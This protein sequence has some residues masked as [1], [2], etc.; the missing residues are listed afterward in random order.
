MPEFLTG[1]K[2]SPHTNCV[3]TKVALQLVWGL[4]ERSAFN[5]LTDDF[6]YAKVILIYENK[7]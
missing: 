7:W 2:I 1:Q 3:L 6:S 4:K 5:S